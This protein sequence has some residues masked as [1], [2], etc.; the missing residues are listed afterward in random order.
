I[1]QH[2]QV[3]TFERV[4]PAR[5]RLLRLCDQA[6][7]RVPIVGQVHGVEV[8]R[9][10]VNLVEILRERFP[11]HK[12]GPTPY[13][14]NLR[15]A[16]SGPGE[17]PGQGRLQVAAA[18]RLRIHSSA[19]KRAE[20]GWAGCATTVLGAPG[21]CA[22]KSTCQSTTLISGCLASQ[23]STLG[24]ACTVA[25][26][27]SCISTMARPRRRDRRVMM[28]RATWSAFLPPRHYLRS[29]VEALWG[30]ARWSTISRNLRQCWP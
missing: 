15:A 24:S 26:W 23:S 8:F 12:H 22:P 11:D 30:E 2:E 18:M 21:A 7:E 25:E 27:V 1:N 4:E 14:I 6:L 10:L 13:S 9:N 16:A 3:L 29:V 28:K 5:E 19:R 20:V 17:G